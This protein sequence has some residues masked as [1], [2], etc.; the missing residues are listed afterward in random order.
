MKPALLFALTDKDGKYF[1][2]DINKDVQ[3]DATPRYIEDPSTW[4]DEQ[5]KWQRNA[6]YLGVIRAQSEL[7]HKF[8]LTGAEILR[9]LYAKYG[10]QAYCEMHVFKKNSTTQ[11]YGLLYKGQLDFSLYKANQYFVTIN[12]MEDALVGLVKA[13][14][15][16]PYSI[17]IEFADS[18]LVYMDGI[19]LNTAYKFFTLQHGPVTSPTAPISGTYYRIIPIAFFDQLGSFTTG[20]A[21]D[22]L[23]IYGTSNS[24]NVLF[25][26]NQDVECTL[27]I[28]INTFY[29]GHSGNSGPKA[30]HM[31]LTIYLDESYTLFNNTI[32]FVDPSPPSPGSGKN[33]NINLT[34]TFTMNQNH[35]MLLSVGMDPISPG[36]NQIDFTIEGNGKIALTTLARTATRTTRGYR[37]GQ[38]LNKLTKALTEGK[39][40]CQS[41]FLND[42]ARNPNT[43]W[44]TTPY[45]NIYT[46]ADAIRKLDTEDTP[47]I[48]QVTLS[49]FKKDLSGKYQVGVGIE[50]NKLVV[51]ELLY[52]FDKNTTIID[53]GDAIK[54]FEHY[55]YLEL[56]GSQINIGY[57]KKELREVNA[58]DEFNVTSVFNTALTR[59]PGT[60]DFV[61][62]YRHDMI[63][64]EILYYNTANKKTVDS[65]S[66]NDIFVLAINSKATDTGTGAYLLDRRPVVN[67][68]VTYPDTAYNVPFSPARNMRRK[69]GYIKSLLQATKTD[70]VAR[71][72]SNNNDTTLV[73]TSSAGYVIAERNYID[74]GSQFSNGAR[75]FLPEIV[76]FTAV[77]PDNFVELMNNKPYGVIKAK[78]ND[79]VFSGFVWDVGMKSAVKN[80]F[81]FKLLLAPDTDVT[82]FIKV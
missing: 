69:A 65:K 18:A 71:F 5:I 47:A 38:V 13:Y 22:A 4:D 39:Y 40:L 31:V 63:G 6:N 79:Y 76:Q 25:T 9:Q 20:R 64:A 21:A 44:D 34:H 11:Q 61:S 8:H 77:P 30:L 45:N 70:Q 26:A 46:C 15:D 3:A 81:T 73:S 56:L 12:L 49:D 54:D 58:V 37:P 52:F 80:T 62:P 42:T 82:R 68:G 57:E 28:D 16:T 24:D 67:A 14:E 29:S 33:L 50:N 10:I 32:L 41:S 72:I 27:E 60:L 59:K 66:D 1:Y 43:L 19:K 35:R 55:P 53:L 7:T 75:I 48:M 78:Y 51:E 23:S 2:L 36:T 74:Y 17:P